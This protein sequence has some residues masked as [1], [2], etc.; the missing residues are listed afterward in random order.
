[1]KAVNAIVRF[2]FLFFVLI[3]LG[4][5]QQV[6]ESSENSV[7]I[8]FDLPSYVLEKSE[9]SDLVSTSLSGEYMTIKMLDD[10]YGVTADGGYPALP[11]L[12]VYVR[13]PSN[14]VD[15]QVSIE[16]AQEESR[17]LPVGT[18]IE[19]YVDYGPDGVEGSLIEIDYYRTA[20]QPHVPV[21]YEL[22]ESFY[23]MGEKAVSFTLFPF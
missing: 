22:S 12:T 15:V 16:N 19:P 23:V 20:S 11:Q 13:V 5:A 7:V 4:E 18:Y 3:G 17:P 8:R 2:F 9:L 14:A 1:M 21:F 6:V 10:A